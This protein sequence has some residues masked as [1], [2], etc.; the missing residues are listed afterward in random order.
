MISQFYVHIHEFIREEN[1]PYTCLCLPSQSWSSFTDPQRAQVYP[2]P[3]WDASTLCTSHDN[4]SSFSTLPY[5]SQYEATNY[6][7]NHISMTSSTRSSIKVMR[8]KI[9]APKSQKLDCSLSNKTLNLSL[10]YFLKKTQTSNYSNVVTG[11]RRTEAKLGHLAIAN[12]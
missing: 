4:Y 9:T 3:L 6:N 10:S 8:V 11:N 5:K 1:E 7:G 12:E 2:G